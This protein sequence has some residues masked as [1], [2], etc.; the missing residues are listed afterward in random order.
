MKKKLALLMTSLLV[1]MLILPFASKAFAY[2][3]GLL[4]GKTVYVGADLDDVSYPKTNITDSDVGTG[5]GL[6]YNILDTIWYK[7]DSPVNITHYQLSAAISSGLNVNFYDANKTLLLSAESVITGVKTPAAVSNVTYVAL[8]NTNSNRPSGITVNEFDVFGVVPINYSGG[9]LDGKTMNKGS[10]E[11]NSYI[12]TLAATD[13]VETTSVSFTSYGGNQDTL[14]YEFSSPV[15]I[16]GYRL[17]SNIRLRILAYDSNGLQIYA[18][19]TV[20]DGSLKTAN[21]SNVKKVAFVNISSNIA[22]LYELNVYGTSTAPP[23]VP[24]NLE[25][26]AVDGKVNLTWEAV[27]AADLA[28]YN[29]YVDGMKINS[30]PIWQASYAASVSNNVN[31]TIQITSID[32]DGNESAKSQPVYSYFD[33]ISPIAPIGLTS[34]PAGDHSTQLQWTANT[35]PDLAGYNVYQDDAQINKSIVI[36]N[37]YMVT[38]LEDNRT[39]SFKVTAIDTS[40]NESPKSAAVTYYMDASAPQ[41]PSG[42]SGTAGTTKVTLT[43]LVPPDED[44]DSYNV[45]QG[46]VLIKS[47]VKDNSF[48][49]DGLTPDTLYNYTVRAVDQ[50][51]NEST[52]SNPL[53]I[54]TEIKPSN[55]PNN[56][57]AKAKDQSI[58]IKW[59]AV[60]DA[61][62]YKIYRN[63]EALATTSETSYLDENL[64]NGVVY[65][66]RISSIIDGAEGEAS[67]AVHARP[68]KQLDLGSSN[69]LNSVL[70][71]IQTTFS[72][73]GKY[74]LYIV[75]VLGLFFSRWIFEFM[76]WLFRKMLP[77]S[78]EEKQRAAE[79][80][81]PKQ[82]QP[83]SPE[84]KERR[85]RERKLNKA[86]DDKYELLTRLGRTSERDRWVK[87]VSYLNREQRQAKAREERN[88]KAREARAAAKASDGGRKSRG[89]RTSGRSQRTGRTSR[90][91]RKGGR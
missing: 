91:G 15:S 11:T 24:S 56:V 71:I 90:G 21:W 27:T 26:S 20:Y 78:K 54:R 77:R 50:S 84:E 32:M 59:D 87:E 83:L 76:A 89:G 16:N 19:D 29:V 13:N 39:Y 79:Q 14:W 10:D 9:L 31:H 30:S 72:F 49:V 36:P 53:S 35:E 60:A 3:G 65:A 33:T 55:I 68:G 46:G 81:Q 42:L 67:N 48:E 75:L 43:W 17:N 38:D 41:P 1:M 80:K 2:P 52:N 63:D 7:F 28:G 88:R 8:I 34:N 44:L 37:E 86:R 57:T 22:T 25:G 62:A 74:K 82:R 4:G 85:A 61:T 69:Q 66:Y 6:T 45:Y 23:P 73:L 58:T 51:G 5:S 12:T 40:S 70:D 64:T 47:N 18:I